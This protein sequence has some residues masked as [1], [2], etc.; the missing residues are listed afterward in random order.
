MIGTTQQLIMP[1]ATIISFV[2]GF[3]S[4]ARIIKPHILAQA[5]SIIIAINGAVAE[6]VVDWLSMTMGGRQTIQFV[7]NTAQ[8]GAYTLCVE[9][10]MYC[11]AI[12]VY[13]NVPGLIWASRVQI[14]R[15]ECAFNI[16]TLGAVQSALQAD[17][18]DSDSESESD[19]DAAP[20]QRTLYQSGSDF[21]LV[22]T[23]L[24]SRF[25]AK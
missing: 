6:V 11:S 1:S 21:N 14:A 19:F 2:N 8:C 22:L 16:R 10:S 23:E 5:P 18:S 13:L 9:N 15:F 12:A 17:D 7:N 25:H 24:N 3:S 4:V 20:S